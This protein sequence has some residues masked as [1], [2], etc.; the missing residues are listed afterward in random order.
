MCMREI[1]RSYIST[2]DC[3]FRSRNGEWVFHVQ[4][5][6]ELQIAGSEG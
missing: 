2:L 3:C 4:H 5:V 6:V 1:T